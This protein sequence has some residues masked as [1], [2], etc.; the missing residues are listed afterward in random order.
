MGSHLREEGSIGYD[1]GLVRLQV[2]SKFDTHIH[3]QE[4]LFSCAV[5]EEQVIKI[6]SFIAFLNIFSFLLVFLFASS[7]FLSSSKINLI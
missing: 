1:G 5:A 6:R 3:H 2:Q 7:D 4:A